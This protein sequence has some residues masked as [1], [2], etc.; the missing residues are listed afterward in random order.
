[1]E[2]IGLARVGQFAEIIEFCSHV[3][4]L[5]VIVGNPYVDSHAVV[6]YGAFLWIGDKINFTES[7][8]VNAIP[9]KLL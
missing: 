3:E 2:I 1:M 7:G 4:I 8:N 9:H 6:V 5:P